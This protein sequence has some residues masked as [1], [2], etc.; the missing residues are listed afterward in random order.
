[1]VTY[2]QKFVA[3]IERYLLYGDANVWNFITGA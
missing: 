2:G 3:I 1:M